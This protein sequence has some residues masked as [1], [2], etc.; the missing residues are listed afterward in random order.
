MS[1]HFFVTT[2]RVFFSKE[3]TTGHPS[4]EFSSV[5]CCEESTDVLRHLL[6][7]WTPQPTYHLASRLRRFS[8]RSFIFIHHTLYITVEVFC[9]LQD[10][11]IH[12]MVNWSL[13]R[14]CL[15]DYI[16]LPLLLG[17][18]SDVRN[19]RSLAGLTSSLLPRNSRMPLLRPSG[20]TWPTC[21]R[22]KIWSKSQYMSYTKIPRVAWWI[23]MYCLWW[24]WE[25]PN[26]RHQVRLSL[27]KLA[28]YT[29]EGVD[30][31]SLGWRR[32]RW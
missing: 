11:I 18:S 7:T 26:W 10:S 31:R 32:R 29:S 13:V 8:R 5:I 15:T 17:I 16:I 21:L 20:S 28:V 9:W 4:Q 3:L 23:Q 30:F 14:C 6:P 19:P 2:T 24:I 12:N 25:F 27:D 1:K 22:W